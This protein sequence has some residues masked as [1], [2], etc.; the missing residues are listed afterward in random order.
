MSIRPSDP[1]EQVIVKFLYIPAIVKIYKTVIES[2][3][4][5]TSS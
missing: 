2:S 5:A 4:K 3:T 1:R